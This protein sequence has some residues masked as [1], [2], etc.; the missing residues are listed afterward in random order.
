MAKLAS[1]KKSTETLS[2]QSHTSLFMTIEQAS[3]FSGIGENT[4]RDIANARKIDYLQV[5]NRKLL[6]VDAFLDFYERNKVSHISTVAAM[7]NAI[8]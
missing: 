3:K 5:G 6:T 4:L 8:A 2:Q 7:Y 1:N